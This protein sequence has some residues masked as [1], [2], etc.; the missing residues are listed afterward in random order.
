MACA[1][2][3]SKCY[4]ITSYPSQRVPA[5]PAIAAIP[6]FKK[7]KSEGSSRGGPQLRASA[8]RREKFEKLKSKK[9]TYANWSVRNAGHVDRP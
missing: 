2:L 4:K 9:N 3:R 6:A 7:L 8:E 1:C 5:I